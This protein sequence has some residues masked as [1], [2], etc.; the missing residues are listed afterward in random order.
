[1]L[2]FEITQ[3]VD[4]F[5]KTTIEPSDVIGKD[6]KP[7]S[8]NVID[9]KGKT[10]ARY[11]SES[12]AR[13]DSAERNARAQDAIDKKNADDEAKRKSSDDTD[14]DKNEKPKKPSLKKR[15]RKEMLRNLKLSWLV[16]ILEVADL[17]EALDDYGDK[18][19][20]YKCDTS[21]PHVVNRYVNVIE[22]LTKAVTNALL[23]AV[24]IGSVARV[25]SAL[26]TNI[27]FLGWA[28]GPIGFASS[29]LLI[30]IAGNMAKDADLMESIAIF[31]ATNFLAP[32]DIIK[33]MGMED[34]CKTLGKTF[35]SQNNPGIPN[36][37]NA[38]AD[39]KT[40]VK[41]FL[42]SDPK[43][44]QEIK[45]AIKKSKQAEA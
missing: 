4:S 17:V 26:A 21:H 34:E 45:K 12:E 28:A 2:I 35:E 39:L 37:S 6:G 22:T 36:K 27:P 18:L 44:K 7:M 29:S 43:M 40:S 42:D 41:N 8:Y 3:N 32:S 20:K 23:T 15:F 38:K 1:M 5:P 9:D 19:S 25:I 14:K 33:A 13:R 30:Y 31:I 24:A 11:D 16:G 10:I